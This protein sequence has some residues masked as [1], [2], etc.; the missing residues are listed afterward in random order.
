MHH[1]TLGQGVGFK[2]RFHGFEIKIS[3][4]I[5]HCQ[6]LIIECLMLIYRIAIALDEIIEKIDMR[7]GVTLQVHGHETG[8]LH[9]AGIN[10]PHETGIGKR[11]RRNYV[12]PEPRQWF[13]FGK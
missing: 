12:L 10:R 4:Q 5:H 8:E 13:G 9:E 2:Y 1:Q 6:I 7:L 11:H 3:G